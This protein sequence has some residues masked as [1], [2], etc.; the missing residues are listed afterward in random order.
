MTGE[1]GAESRTVDAP[2]PRPGYGESWA[3]MKYGLV[4]RVG[5]LD[6]VLG[7]NGGGITGDLASAT[8]GV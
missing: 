5:D 4:D 8:S 7:A 1:G 2:A 6:R 3:R